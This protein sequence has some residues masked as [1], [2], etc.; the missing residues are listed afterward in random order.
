MAQVQ[1]QLRAED[2]ENTQAEG[3]RKQD[4]RFTDTLDTVPVAEYNGHTEDQDRLLLMLDP[5]QRVIVH[6]Q[7]PKG[8][9]PQG[10]HEADGE[11]AH[12]VHVL[13]S[14]DQHAGDRKGNHAGHFQYVNDVKHLRP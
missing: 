10:G 13:G 1:S 8:S 3:I 7:V 5:V 11:N 6:H 2:R 12:R 9:S 14:G 4:A